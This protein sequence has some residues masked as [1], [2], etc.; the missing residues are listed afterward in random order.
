MCRMA[1]Y[2]GAAVPLAVLLSDPPHSL[3]VQAYQPRMQ[4]EG[5][6]NVDGTG[7]AWWPPGD[8][9]PLRYVTERPPWSDPN[10]LPLAARLCGVAQ[11]AAVRSATPGLPFGPDAV[12]PFVR[13]GVALAHNG[14]VGGFPGRVGR[15]LLERLPDELLTAAGVLTDSVVLFLTALHH[16]RRQPG[17]GLASA[18]AGAVHEVE[19]ACAHA[20]QA[21]TLTLLACDGQ[22]LVGIRAA[23]GMRSPTLFTRAG[24]EHAGL[25]AASE[26]LDDTPGWTEV[27]DRH[28]V[29]L[30]GTGVTL[31]P[32]SQEGPR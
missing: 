23:A 32:L 13:Y 7:V 6:V 10:L 16:R 30:T 31:T 8:A 26:P 14:R 2:L 3:T 27:P 4:H 18:L 19:R 28:V 17:H 21:A 29:E 22:R 11:L 25:V 12:A 1:G 20:G 9:E 24:P 5:T 15:A